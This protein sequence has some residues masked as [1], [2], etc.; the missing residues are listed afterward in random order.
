[1]HG[2]W[3]S[4][5]PSPRVP[6]D[7][8]GGGWPLPEALRFAPQGLCLSFSWSLS[9]QSSLSPAGDNL[10]PSGSPE[11]WKACATP[12]GSERHSP[13]TSIPTSPF[14][15]RL[16]GFVPCFVSMIS[17]R[18]TAQLVGSW[19]WLSNIPG[20]AVMGL[21]ALS[22]TQSFIKMLLCL[23]YTVLLPS[24]SHLVSW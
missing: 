11:D 24:C 8:P 21:R 18:G 15:H 9:P 10:S 5:R 6:W 16:Y 14:Y 23:N 3:S 20:R 19:S 13:C 7:R 12:S 22:F 2:Y 17:R 4:V 1:M